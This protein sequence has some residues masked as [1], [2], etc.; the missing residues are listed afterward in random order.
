[1]I[2]SR[3]VSLQLRCIQKRMYEDDLSFENTKVSF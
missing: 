1:M 2:I 3:V